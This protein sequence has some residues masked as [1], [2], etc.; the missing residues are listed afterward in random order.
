MD[1]KI[2]HEGDFFRPQK[3]SKRRG[4]SRLGK[5]AFLLPAKELGLDTH[6]TATAATVLQVLQQK[7]IQFKIKQTK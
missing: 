3:S 1:G 6:S 4:N 7:H 5:F 2:C